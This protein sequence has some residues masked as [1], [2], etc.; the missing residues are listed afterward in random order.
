MRRWAALAVAL[1]VLL[2]SCSDDQPRPADSS[3]APS[4]SPD[5]VDDATTDVSAADA[6]ADAVEERLEIFRGIY[7]GAV[8]LLRVGDETRF[9]TAGHADLGKRTRITERHRFQIASVT[10]TMVATIVL[11]LVEDDELELADSVDSWLPGQVPGGDRIT[12]EQLLSHRSGLYDFTDSP[13]FRWINR[14]GPVDIVR[15]ATTEEPVSAP[16]TQSSY[17]NTNYV[18]LGLLIERITGKDLAEVMQK[19]IFAPVGMTDT[20]ADTARVTD[21]PLVRGYD[22]RRDVTLDD[23]SS[24]LA[25]GGVVSS[26]RDLDA[27]FDAL[28]GGRLLTSATF[29]DMARPRG[30]L[31][32]RQDS[33]YGLGLGRG[34]TRCNIVV[35]HGGGLP[36][37]LTEALITED[38]ERSVV[39][40]VNDAGSELPLDGL[41]DTALCG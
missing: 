1:G 13:R 35:G 33:E 37:F 30:R 4:K 5:A 27:F 34:E 14:W 21:P 24:V 8:V 19:Q 10:K 16:D 22:G 17:S 11:Q 28:T 15:L 41:V 18:L 9:V 31:V 6:A 38:G 25:A 32:N 23:L 26:A 36:G 39:V 3:A 40:M 12:V 7:P 29:H 20:S 2:T